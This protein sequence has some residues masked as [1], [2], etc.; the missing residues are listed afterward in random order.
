[1][2]VG[3]EHDPP[4]VSLDPLVRSFELI[5]AEVLQLRLGRRVE[6][7]RSGLVHP[8]HQRA[9]V[10]A[11]EVHRP[12]AEPSAAAD[13]TRRFVSGDAKLSGGGPCR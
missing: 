3:Y 9:R 12:G 10:F 5:A 13:P 1:V 4:L 6:V 11:W 8:V 7:V 2:V